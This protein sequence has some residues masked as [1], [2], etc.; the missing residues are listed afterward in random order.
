MGLTCLGFAVL[1]PICRSPTRGVQIIFENSVGLRRKRFFLRSPAQCSFLFFLGL[2]DQA[3]TKL[4]QNA[5]AHLERDIDFW[6]FF[7]GLHSFGDFCRSPVRV[8]KKSVS[9]SAFLTQA[10]QFVFL[11]KFWALGFAILELSP[12]YAKPFSGI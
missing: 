9:A 7:L 3:S 1:H 6:V 8:K 12:W 4:P 11:P 10:S 5:E 2:R